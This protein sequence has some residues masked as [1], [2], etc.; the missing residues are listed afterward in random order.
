MRSDPG[1]RI[2]RCG[3]RGCLNT[4]ASVETLADLLRVTHGQL[5]LR[6]IVQRA[7]DGDAGCQQAVAHAAAAIGAAAAD[8]AVLLAPHRVCLSG[9]LTATGAVFIDSVRRAMRSRPLLPDPDGFVVL[10]ECEAPEARGALAIAADLAESS[11]RTE[12]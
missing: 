4:L 1:G 10:A 11:H 9:E 6:E 2:C 7:N 8:A 3:A 5:S 12:G